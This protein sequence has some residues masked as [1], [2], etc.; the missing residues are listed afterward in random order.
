VRGRFWAKGIL[1]VTYRFLSTAVFPRGWEIIFTQESLIAITLGCIA[2]A[3]GGST[4][5]DSG[6]LVDVC[7]GFVGYGAIALGFCVAGVTIALTLPD[8]T[9]VKKLATF[10]IPDHHGDALSSLLFVF[11]WTAVVHWIAVVLVLL[12][13]L[14]FGSKDGHVLAQSSV[15]SRAFVGLSVCMCAYAL[16][17]FLITVMTLWQIGCT[18]IR[19]LQ[20]DRN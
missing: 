2:G 1:N 17:Q 12:I 3:I 6:K 10:T 18:Y 5:P 13:L 19:D 4:F 11:C 16:S 7:L 9:F 8:K 20:S 14:C 15:L